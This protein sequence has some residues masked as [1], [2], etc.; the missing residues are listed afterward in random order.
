MLVIGI[1]FE[2]SRAY[3]YE[4]DTTAM[5]GIHVGVYLEYE[6]CEVFLSGRTTLSTAW[7]GLGAGAIFT[8]QSSNSFTPNIFSAEPK[9]TGAILAAK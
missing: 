8:K 2:F 1:S 6:P 7:M 5:I 4:S 9:N 3:F